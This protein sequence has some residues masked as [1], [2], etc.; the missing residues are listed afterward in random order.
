MYIVVWNDVIVAMDSVIP[1]VSGTLKNAYREH[2]LVVLPDYQGLGIGT[3]LSNTLGQYY[4]DN[5]YKFFCRSTHV[6]LANNRLKES[7]PWLETSSSNKLRVGVNG[8]NSHE[9]T[10]DDK[11]IAYSFEYVG[12][13]YKNK[14]HLR[15]VIKKD[16]DLEY[17][18]K[19]LK[20]ALEK[21]KDYYLIV[22]IGVA[23]Q[24]ESYNYEI[25]CKELGI[26]T[27]ILY[28]KSRG[29]YRENKKPLD[30]IVNIY[31]KRLNEQRVI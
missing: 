30:V 27:E 18:R 20:Q 10:Y 1:I 21:Y 31:I 22:V 7:S 11:R 6:K 23:K 19:V 9:F 14:E 17:C 2:R 4:I 29:E 13:D 24:D 12:N 8:K 15:I 26:R 16:R 3:T 25:A 5:G 28:I